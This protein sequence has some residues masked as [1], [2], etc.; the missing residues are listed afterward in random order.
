MGGQYVDAFYRQTSVDELRDE[1]TIRRSSGFYLQVQT[2]RPAELEDPAASSIGLSYII[3]EV[4]I[5]STSDVLI[6]SEWNE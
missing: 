1:L 6:S 5:K 3:K 4:W 2:S